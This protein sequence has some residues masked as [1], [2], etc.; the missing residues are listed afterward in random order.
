MQ[1]IYLVSNSY[2]LFLK[3]LKEGL[4]VGKIGQGMRYY[5]CNSTS[6]VSVVCETQKKVY[7]YGCVSV[8][9]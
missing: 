7:M 8:T 5:K 4:I 2:F 1:T 9:Q 3:N 6:H